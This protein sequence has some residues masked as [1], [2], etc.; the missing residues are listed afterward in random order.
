MRLIV[1]TPLATLI[2]TDDVVHVRAEDETGAFGVLEHHADFVTALSVCV[3]SWRGAPGTEH[4]IAVRGGMLETRG[5]H[6]VAV[7]TPE[8]VPGDDLEVLESEVLRRFRER[9]DAERAARVDAQRL[10]IAAIRQIIAL[11]RPERAA[12]I[13][14]GIRPHAVG[15]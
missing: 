14:G 3:L 9:L 5:G 11:L 12:P 10:H 7:A 6:R 8:A 15:S 2:E 1:A 13:G 4:H